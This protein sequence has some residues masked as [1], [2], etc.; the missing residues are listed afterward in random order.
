MTTSS[1]IRH[2]NDSTAANVEQRRALRMREF[3][4]GG[5]TPQSIARLTLDPK[6]F[7]G[8]GMPVIAAERRP[9]LFQDRVHLV[10]RLCRRRWSREG[11]HQRVMLPETGRR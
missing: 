7:L 3:C 1:P 9:A 2:K 10:A 8:S 11:I 5:I 6:K 4:A